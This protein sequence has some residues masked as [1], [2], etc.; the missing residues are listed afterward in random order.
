MREVYRAV[1]AARLV[2]PAFEQDLATENP[3]PKVNRTGFV[4]DLL[5]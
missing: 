3:K 1:G 5:T 2:R 4:G